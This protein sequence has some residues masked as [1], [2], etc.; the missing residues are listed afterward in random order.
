MVTWEKCPECGRGRGEDHKIRCHHRLHPP[1]PDYSSRSVAEQQQE[2]LQRP[3]NDRQM[4]QAT[5]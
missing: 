5:E 4:A 3:A 2:T 1:V